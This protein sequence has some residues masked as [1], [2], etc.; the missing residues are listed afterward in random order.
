M[1]DTATV[2]DTPTVPSCVTLG[3]NDP[4][5]V[6]TVQIPTNI[7]ESVIYPVGSAC[8]M[9]FNQVQA[10]LMNMSGGATAEIAVYDNLVLVA[11][12]PVTVPASSE[13]WVTASIPP[14]S[15]NCGDS[16]I[17][18]VHSLSPSLFVGVSPAGMNC[19]TDSGTSATMMPSTYPNANAL[20][21]PSTG[22]CYEVNLSACGSGANPTPSLAFSSNLVAM[23]NILGPGQDET[24]LSMDST[25]P[26]GGTLD[27]YDVTGELVA[28]V[29]SDSSSSDSLVHNS[30]LSSGQAPTPTVVPFSPGAPSHPNDGVPVY[31]HHYRW[32]GTTASGRKVASGIYVALVHDARG[33]HTTRI[34]VLR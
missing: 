1:T 33:S 21:N 29:P 26:S 11:D 2:T 27:L 15:F 22:Y 5:P 10:Y 30:S 20:T 14:V 28:M 9:N 24:T 12:V 32:K 23:P 19:A 25:D 3:Q 18:T 16:V 7:Y 8:G 17:L 34:L 31:R 13:G 6:V 4:M